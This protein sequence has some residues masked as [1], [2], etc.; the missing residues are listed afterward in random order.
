[1]KR[2]AD[3]YERELENRLALLTKIIEPLL[4]L[5]MGLVVG[6]IVSSLILPIFKLSRAIH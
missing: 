6:L 1:M 5:V 3:F 2:V 4:L